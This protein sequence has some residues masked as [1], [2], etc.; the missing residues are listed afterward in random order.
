MTKV[1]FV[2]PTAVTL[3]TTAVAFAGTP[4]MPVTFTRIDCAA[5][6]LALATTGLTDAGHRPVPVRVSKTRHG[7]TA[8]YV[9]GLVASNDPTGA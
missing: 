5:P 2:A 6:T 1:S 3:S 8:R 7:A 4:L 9:D